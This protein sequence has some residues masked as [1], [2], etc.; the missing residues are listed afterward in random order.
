MP[1]QPLFF[2]VSIMDDALMGHWTFQAADELSVMRHLLRDPWSY[3]DV[4]WGLRISLRDI[5]R[6]TPEEL[7][8]V[9]TDSYGP[10]KTRTVL[11]LIRVPAGEICDIVKEAMPKLDRDSALGA[12]PS[13]MG[14]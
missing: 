8:Q 10:A 5:E 6:V 4:F 7:L 1:D 2:L 3:E 11:Y 9:I 12:A 13:G 14:Q